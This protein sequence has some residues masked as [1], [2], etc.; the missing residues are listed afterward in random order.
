MTSGLN[1]YQ[2]IRASLSARIQQGDWCVGA[3]LP[4]ERQLSEQFHTTRVTL[5]EALASLEADGVIYREDRRGWFVAPD[6][7]TYNPTINANFHQ[8]VQSQNRVPATKLVEAVRV[9]A[10]LKVQ[11]A[12]DIDSDS[13]VYR[14]KRLRSVDGRTVLYTENYIQP[15]FFPDLLQ[16]DLSHSL[17]EL[18][19]TYYGTEYQRVNFRLYPLGLTEEV[20]SYLKVSS[21]SPGL[22]VTRL[23]RDQHQRIIDCDFEYWRPDAVV[24][25]VETR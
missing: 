14:L 24:I 7:L 21:G 13:E 15:A 18:Y 1:Q 22:L 9:T 2:A 19:S 3:K 6:R 16:H 10:P 25:E 23:N 17:S 4:S 11:K 20:A 5:R 8:M 12:M